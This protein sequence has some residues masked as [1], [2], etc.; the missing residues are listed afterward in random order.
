MTSLA[1]INEMNFWG[2]VRPGELV[3][4]QAVGRVAGFVSAAAVVGEGVGVVAAV[5]VAVEMA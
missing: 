2:N 1:G 3:C 5:A 4:H